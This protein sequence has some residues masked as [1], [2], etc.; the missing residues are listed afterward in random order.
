MVRKK[1]SLFTFHSPPGFTLVEVLVAVL[2]LGFGLVLVIEAMGRTQHA[3]RIS[4]NLMLASQLA[5]NQIVEKEME[6]RQDY[7]LRSGMDTGKIEL[8]GRIFNYENSVNVFRAENI[9]DETKLSRFDVKFNWSEGTRK[10][11][12]VVA[13]LL[14]NREKVQQ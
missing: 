4:K 8:P 12:L 9:I 7:K 3:L 1:I 6:L 14:L 10:N 11:E 13:T 5:E 2:I